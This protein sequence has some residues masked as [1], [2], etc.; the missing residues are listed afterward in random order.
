MDDRL[1]FRVR[2]AITVTVEPDKPEETE[3]P[4]KMEI[5]AETPRRP[6]ERGAK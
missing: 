4:E 3:A 1:R 6:A 2:P 5:K